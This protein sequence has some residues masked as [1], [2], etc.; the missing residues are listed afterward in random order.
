M[1]KHKKRRGTF[2]TRNLGVLYAKGKYIII[3]DPDDIINKNIL[4]I[5]YQY[6]EKFNYD[7]IRFNIYQGEE[8]INYNIKAANALI[9][10]K[11]IQPELSTSI[12]Y[13]KNEL[14]KNDLNIYNKLIKKE[15]YIISLNSISKFYLKIYIIFWEDQIMNLILYRTAKSFYF[16]NKIGYYYIKNSMSITKRDFKLE[17]LKTIFK[18]LYLKFI[19]EYS[20]NTK[21]EK[22]MANI[23]LTTFLKNEGLFFNNSNYN[24]FYNIINMFVISKYITNNNKYLLLYMK[25]KL[26]KK[27]K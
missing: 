15:I 24:F 1:I 26:R 25:N 12:F 4:S 17:Q 14:E 22:D 11:L 7:I 10:T 8:I 5:S 18:F 20:K 21:Y 9:N 6:A 13:V 23:Q 19:F 27:K 2:F 3:P 16:I